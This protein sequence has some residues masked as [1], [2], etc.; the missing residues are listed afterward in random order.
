MLSPNI[1]PNKAQ[2]ARA[3]QLWADFGHP[4]QELLHL[5]N[6]YHARTNEEVARDDYLSN[7]PHERN[8]VHPRIFEIQVWTS[9]RLPRRPTEA[10]HPLMLDANLHTYW[11]MFIEA[12]KRFDQDDPNQDA[13]VVE[14]LSLQR[15]T[16]QHAFGNELV[17]AYASNGQRIWTD[18][19]YFY[20]DLLAALQGSLTRDQRTNLVAFIARLASCGV[21][22]NV[23]F[24]FGL[25]LFRDALESSRPLLPSTLDPS[26][27]VQ[28]LLPSVNCW[29]QL[30]RYHIETFLQESVD[31]FDPSLSTPGPLAP[32]G[33]LGGFNMIRWK[34]WGQRLT[35]LSKNTDKEVS[36]T[37]D[38]IM[39]WWSEIDGHSL[40]GN[41]PEGEVKPGRY[42]VSG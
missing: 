18:L 34:F 25:L 30:T 26:T 17:P 16:L 19:P 37:A 35:E 28:D 40:G 6:Q 27:S 39:S 41:D 14:L 7:M 38:S 33:C 29:I 32:K 20:D 8:L 21:F 9:N 5:N 24:G 10:G 23:L 13:L 31:N 12:A 11:H 22:D 36:D 4:S 15:R 42:W 2:Q 3:L 1:P